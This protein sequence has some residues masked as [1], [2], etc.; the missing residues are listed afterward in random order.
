VAIEEVIEWIRQQMAFLNPDG[1]PSTQPI[2]LTRT[3]AQLLLDWYGRPSTAP[4]V[5]EAFEVLAEQASPP[6]GRDTPA[7]RRLCRAI[8]DEHIDA[9]EV[10]RNGKSVMWT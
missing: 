1:G 4:S 5:V 3:E 9:T 2:F 6:E 8:I 10:A 7:Y